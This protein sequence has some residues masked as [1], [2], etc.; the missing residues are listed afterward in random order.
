MSNWSNSD[1]EKQNKNS[2]A[3]TSQHQE[4]AHVHTTVATRPATLLS[5]DFSPESKLYLYK[6][7]YCPVDICCTIS[8]I[9][10]CLPRL[11]STRL[12]AKNLLVHQPLVAVKI[13]EI[14]LTTLIVMMWKFHKECKCKKQLYKNTGNITY[15]IHIY[16]YPMCNYMHTAVQRNKDIWW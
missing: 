10:P 7:N 14:W 12:D 16:W 13:I 2:H 1:H 15:P 9:S 3:F 5:K 4:Q 6:L 8:K 11:H